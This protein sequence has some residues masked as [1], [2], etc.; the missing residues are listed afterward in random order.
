MCSVATALLSVASISEKLVGML[1]AR[2]VSGSHMALTAAFDLILFSVKL[3]SHPPLSLR[4]L[5]NLTA[6]CQ[7]VKLCGISYM[8]TYM[9][10]VTGA[11]WKKETGLIQCTIQVFALRD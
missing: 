8:Y 1:R 2:A 4:L 5:L 10:N 7:L 11:I 3:R 6:I 9:N